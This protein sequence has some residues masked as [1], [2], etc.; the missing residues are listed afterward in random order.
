MKMKSDE[1]KDKKPSLL[2]LIYSLVIAI[3]SGKYL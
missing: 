2:V 3:L 1:S